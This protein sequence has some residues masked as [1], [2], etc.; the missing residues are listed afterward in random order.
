MSEK[1]GEGDL[2]AF[3]DCLSEPRFRIRLDDEV[4]AAVRETLARMSGENFP[5]ASARVT[6]DDFAARLAAYEK[7]VRP[8][9]AMAA[10]LG[11]WATPEQVPTLT[12]MLAR[13]A[14][15]FADAQNGQ[16]LWTEMRAYP[17]NVVLYSAGMAALASDN[18]HA[19]ASAHLKHLDARTRR[20]SNGQHAVAVPVVDAMR[21]VASTGIWRAVEEYKQ[22]R[23]PESEHLHKVL[24]PA[25][26][27]L[28]FFGAGYER[29]FDRYEVLR[30]LV[31]ADLTDGGWGPVGR[32]GWKYCSRNDYDNPFSDVRA[33]AAQQKDTWGP[34]RAGLFGG[35]RARFEQTVAK[36]QKELL[37]RLEWY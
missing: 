25:L 22:K 27:D 13:L 3:K 9:Q 23:V 36:Y 19:F 16:T 33:E 5:L 32:F 17:L 37:D 20:T 15:T 10:L 7:A 11:K 4:N 29:L 26:D 12:G 30:A 31:Y 8:L 35:S 34:I 2:A 24:R 28:L 1:T 21:E 18:Y 6:G 14:D